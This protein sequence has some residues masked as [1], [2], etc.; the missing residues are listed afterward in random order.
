MRAYTIPAFGLEHLAVAGR[1]EPK[2]RPGEVVVRVRRNGTFA[3]L[4]VTDTGPGISEADR[5][6]IFEEFQQARTE[7]GRR[8]GTGLG[9]AITRR[10]VALHHGTITVQS[11][12]GRGSTFEVNL[13]IGNVDAPPSRKTMGPMLNRTPPTGS[14]PP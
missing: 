3:Y 11:E 2:P 10:L 7:R 1:P 4:S 14:T 6:L 12:L 5:A 13:P 9:L 8:R